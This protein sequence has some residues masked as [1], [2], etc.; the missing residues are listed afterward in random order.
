ML[1]PFS[2][3]IGAM[4][5]LCGR[6]FFCIGLWIQEKEHEVFLV[7]SHQVLELLCVVSEICC[8]LRPLGSQD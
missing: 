3:V 8:F 5:A 6:W 7:G 2:P 1:Q 4:V